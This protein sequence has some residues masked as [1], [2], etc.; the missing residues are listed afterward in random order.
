MILHNFYP[1]ISLY[2]LT[3]NRWNKVTLLSY[4]RFYVTWMLPENTLFGHFGY[5]IPRNPK[6]IYHDLSCFPLSWLQ[7]SPISYHPVILFIVYR[8][9]KKLKYPKPPVYPCPCLD[10]SHQMQDRVSLLTR[11]SHTSKFK[12]VELFLSHH[13]SHDNL[14]SIWHSQDQNRSC[15]RI[16]STQF[17]RCPCNSKQ[18]G[19]SNSGQQCYQQQP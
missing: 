17:Q 15:H 5:I 4:Y 11:S 18:E 2:S 3:W 9:T 10:I 8:L 6:K 16:I 1:H 12:Y 13:E 7:I 14:N 19:Q